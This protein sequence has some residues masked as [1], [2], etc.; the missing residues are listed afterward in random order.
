[1]KI[2]IFRVD[3]QTI[4]EG[5]KRVNNSNGKKVP[6]QFNFFNTYM[7]SP[8]QHSTQF[9]KKKIEIDETTPLKALNI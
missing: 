4:S 9:L 6:K 1:M 8:A 5:F 3:R 2:I 7:T